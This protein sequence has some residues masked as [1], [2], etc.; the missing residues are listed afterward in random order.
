[1]LAGGAHP[2]Y[3]PEGA[4]AGGRALSSTARIAATS[5]ELRVYI[6]DHPDF[7]DIGNRMLREW[8]QGVALS[9]KAAWPEP[10]Y[11]NWYPLPFESL[12]DLVR[13]SVHT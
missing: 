12:Q 6:K 11:R 9:L 10:P 8:E 5:K 3:R 1:V 4:A 7:E 13:A 2:L